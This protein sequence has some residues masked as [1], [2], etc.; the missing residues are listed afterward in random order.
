MIVQMT[1]EQTTNPD[2][3]ETEV[4]KPKEK[5]PRSILQDEALHKARQKAYENRRLRALVGGREHKTPRLGRGTNVQSTEELQQ[6]IQGLEEDNLR[7][8][9]EAAAAHELIERTVHESKQEGADPFLRLV[10]KKGDPYS[11]DMIELGLKLMSRSLSS[12]Q[13]WGAMMDYGTTLHPHLQPGEDYRVP[14]A[15]QFR[16]WRRL[17]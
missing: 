5:K 3:N 13:A 16:I 4:E 17:L 9:D 2:V 10:G 14:S 12:V 11:Q 15:S 1:E 7:L 8:V 6:H